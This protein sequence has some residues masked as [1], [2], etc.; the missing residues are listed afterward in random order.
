MKFELFIMNILAQFV[1]IESKKKKKKKNYYILSH[2]DLGR[3][4]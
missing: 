3:H 1:L 2:M 4:V